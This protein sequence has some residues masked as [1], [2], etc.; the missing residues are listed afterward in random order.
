MIA[1]IVKAWWRFVAWLYSKRPVEPVA[2]VESPEEYHRR[3][4]IEIAKHVRQGRWEEIP[5]Q[6]R[7]ISAEEAAAFLAEMQQEPAPTGRVS[8]SATFEVAME[9]FDPKK[10]AEVAPPRPPLALKVER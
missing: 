10:K 7:R 9:P 5:N 1:A 6:P 2:P 3:Q 4:L 8:R